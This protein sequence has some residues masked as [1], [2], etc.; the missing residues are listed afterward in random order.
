MGESIILKPCIGESKT[1]QRGTRFNMNLRG[2][3]A[4]QRL[5]SIWNQLPEEVDVANIIMPFKIYLGGV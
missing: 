5:V 4:T 2:R 3:F 1:F